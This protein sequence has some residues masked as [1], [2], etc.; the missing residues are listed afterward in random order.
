MRL[1]LWPESLAGRTFMV[2][3]LGLLTAQA[4]GLAIHGFDRVGALRLQHMR[5][6]SERITQLWRMLS[7]APAGAR[8]A[9]LRDFELMPG[10]T[11]SLDDTPRTVAEPPPHFMMRQPA[12]GGVLRGPPQLRPRET[13]ISGTEPSG[14]VMLALRFADG[15]WLN[16]TTRMPPPR[17]WHSPTFLAAFAVMSV[18]VALLSLWAV[19]RLTRPVTT[20]ALAA[21]R[22][23]RDVNAPPLPENGPREVR[24]AA[25][26]FNTMARRIQ[27]FVADRTAMLAAISH[28]LRTPITRMKLRAEFIDDAELRARM[29]S[30]LD[31]MERMVAATLAFARDDA[32][33]EKPGPVDVA[34]LLRTLADEANDVAGS[35]LV[36]VEAPAH[37]AL[38]ARA[39]ALKRALS[40]LVG[41]ALSH[42]GACRLRL[43]PPA[44]GSAHILIEDD[45]PGIPDDELERVFQPFHRLDPARSREATDQSSGGVGLG[46]PIARNILRAH[47]GDVVLRNRSPHG[48]TATVTLPA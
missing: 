47:G 9:L 12:P 35:E 32:A 29:L 18:S 33:A 17:F 4:V 44:E 6:N 46:L 24:Q 28:D 13:R 15:G 20:L 16:V 3:L 10:T 1:K 14:G 19:R 7:A 30:D 5:E 41:N 11:A 45:G 23:G 43:L 42:S 37:L 26:A 36:E 40:N 8:P 22:L 39:V 38:P 48:L 21:E 2:L 27:K 31:E 25:S 34:A